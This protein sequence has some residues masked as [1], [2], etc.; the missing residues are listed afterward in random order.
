MIDFRSDTFTKPSPQMLDA[1]FTAEVGDDVFGE[2]PTINKLEIMMAD[3]FGMDA[4]LFCPSG[5]MTNQIAIKCH[6]QPGDEVICEKMSHVYIYEGGGIAFNSLCSVKLVEG[7]LGRITADQVLEAINP[8]DIHKPNSSLVSL[9]NTAN[10]GGGS[11]YNYNDLVNIKKVCKKN[12]LLL[13]LDGAR[14]YNALVAKNQTPKQYGDVFDSI[15]ICLSKGLGT[16]VGSVL[17]GKKDFIAK[18]RRIRKVFGGGMRQGGYLAAAG[19]FAL[20]NNVE[21]LA[22]DHLHAKMICEAL[23]AKDFVGTFLPVETNILIFE[24]T[25]RFTPVALA[26]K[27]EENN[28]RVMAISRTQVRMVLHLDILPEQVEKTIETIQDL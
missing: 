10:R 28:I 7:N 25:G 3:S 8:N 17:I 1:M 19:I 27:L 16:P 24:V 9:E 5:T 15:S 4:G 20:E 26:K 14:L 23:Q 22:K 21:R 11:C 13:H 12:N 2:D 18:A 6:T